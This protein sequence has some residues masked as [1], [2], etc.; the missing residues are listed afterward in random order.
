MVEVTIFDDN[1]ATTHINWDC[2]NIKC[3]G[4]LG[5]SAIF[6]TGKW[7]WGQYGRLQYI[8]QP[9]NPHHHHG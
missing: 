1:E 5:L 3:L 4:V 9:N 6:G 8:R 2:F 7:Q